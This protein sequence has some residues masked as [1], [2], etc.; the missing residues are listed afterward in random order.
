MWET[1]SLAKNQGMDSETQNTEKARLL[2]MALQD[3]VSGN[4][5]HPVSL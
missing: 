5:A 2:M 3:R 1:H 4:W